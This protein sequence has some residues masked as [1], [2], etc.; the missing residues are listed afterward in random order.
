[1]DTETPRYILSARAVYDYTS[2]HADEL[3]LR[4]GD[5]LEILDKEEDPWWRARNS[6]NGKM[7]LVPKNY[8]NEILPADESDLPKGWKMSI[9]PKSGEAYFYNKKTGL[10]CCI[11]SLCG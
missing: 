3:S 10:P 11:D 8:V 6:T 4:R 9:D 2:T 7:G 5:I 1:M